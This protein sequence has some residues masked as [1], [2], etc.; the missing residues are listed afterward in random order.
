MSSIIPHIWDRKKSLFLDTIIQDNFPS[1]CLSK[2]Q[3]SKKTAYF[4]AKGG[5]QNV[6]CLILQC[7]TKDSNSGGHTIT[8]ITSTLLVSKKFQW[9]SDAKWKLYDHSDGG[10]LS[11]LEIQKYEENV[12]NPF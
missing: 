6:I 8:G 1:V 12:L 3:L 11:I 5:Y 10:E 2:Q 7:K 9:K 4:E